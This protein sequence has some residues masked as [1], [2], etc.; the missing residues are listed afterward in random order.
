MLTNSL[1]ISDT[2]KIKFFELIFSQSDQKKK[3]QKYCRLDLKQC[4]GAFNMLTAHKCSD[5]GI[6]RYLSNLAFYS[7]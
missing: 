7:L 3:W 2:T 1:K 5:T 4:F 6:F